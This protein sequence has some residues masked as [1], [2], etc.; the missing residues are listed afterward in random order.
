MVGVL[1][2]GDALRHRISSALRVV[3]RV[4]HRH[5]LLTR[6]RQIKYDSLLLHHK[7]I[8]RFRFRAA[9]LLQAPGGAALRADGRDRSSAERVL[10]MSCN[11]LSSRSRLCQSQRVMLHAPVLAWA[12]AADDDDG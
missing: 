4:N 3:L 2:T 9:R 8:V 6:S 5:N 7:L 1:T 10:N 12:A 11:S